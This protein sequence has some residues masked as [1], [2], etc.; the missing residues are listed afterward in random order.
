MSR[1]FTKE[2]LTYFNKKMLGRGKPNEEDGLG[3]NKADYGTCANYFYGLSNAQY[4]DLAKRLIKYSNTQL[5]INKEDMKATYEHFK[6][7]SNGADKNK[8]IS[9][10]ITDKGVIISF[11]Y[12][13]TFVETIKKQ[14]ERKWNAEKKKWIVP[15]SRVGE[16]LKNLENVGAD[17][18]N[19]LEYAYQHNCFKHV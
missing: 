18:K 10:N 7:L 4:E 1:I 15:N 19:A 16:V 6:K 12:D 5:G 8:G 2:E 3:Y 17:V 9:L 14:P 13:K 11:R